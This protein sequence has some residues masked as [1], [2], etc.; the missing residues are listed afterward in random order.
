MNRI[1]MIALL[2]IILASGFANATESKKIDDIDK[3]KEIL[4]KEVG[5]G[6]QS[7]EYP[8]FIIG[9]DQKINPVSAI[10]NITYTSNVTKLW[11]KTEK[12][13][14]FIGRIDLYH[15][16]DL[17]QD[18]LFISGNEIYTITTK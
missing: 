5:Q 10:N 7:E 14:G 11:N 2:A 8:T 1:Y 12:V 9:H 4:E 6:L 17:D 15:V 3:I 18:V 13:S 16:P